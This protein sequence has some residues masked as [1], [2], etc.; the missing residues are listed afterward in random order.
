VFVEPAFCIVRRA[1]VH[2]PAAFAT[3]AD[4]EQGNDVFLCQYEYDLGW[5]RFR[6]REYGPGAGRGSLRSGFAWVWTV[7]LVL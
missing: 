5:K 3:A 1:F 6:Q 2:G 4:S 7:G